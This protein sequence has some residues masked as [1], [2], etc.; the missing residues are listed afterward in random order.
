MGSCKSWGGVLD[1]VPRHVG[2]YIL[3][4]GFSLDLW[5]EICIQAFV[6]YLNQLVSRYSQ[7]LSVHYSLRWSFTVS[8]RVS[9]SQQ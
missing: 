4:G 1:L 9:S 2:D 7:C 3:N 8:S 5:V 6:I